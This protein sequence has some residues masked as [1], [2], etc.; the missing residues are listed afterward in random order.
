MFL[1]QISLVNY[2]ATKNLGNPKY[3]VKMEICKIVQTSNIAEVKTVIKTQYLV[4]EDYDT[5]LEFAVKLINQ[6]GTKLGENADQH[7]S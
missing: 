4:N 6:I 5:I 3:V 7:A 1:F 2:I